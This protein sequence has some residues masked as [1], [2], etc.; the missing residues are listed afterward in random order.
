MM[1]IL[2]LPLII[3]TTEIEPTSLRDHS[4]CQA[5]F[6]LSHFSIATPWGAGRVTPLSMVT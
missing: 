2:L 5:S 4:G 6:T 3:G 1:A